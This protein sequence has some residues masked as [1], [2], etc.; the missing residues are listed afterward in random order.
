MPLFNA[1]LRLG[2]SA[3]TA[4]DAEKVAQIVAERALEEYGPYAPS[5]VHEEIRA[6]LAEASVEA[7]AD[8]VNHS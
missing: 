1:E 3:D 4:E 5:D 2:I 7:V 8:R 6:V